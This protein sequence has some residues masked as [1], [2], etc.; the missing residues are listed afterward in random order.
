MAAS[1]KPLTDKEDYLSG[2]HTGQQIDLFHFLAHDQ[3]CHCGACPIDGGEP[4]KY[5]FFISS[6]RIRLMGNG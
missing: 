1:V 2:H 6:V 5:N 3:K 4:V